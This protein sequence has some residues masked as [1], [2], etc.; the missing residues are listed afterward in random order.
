MALGLYVVKSNLKYVN[1]ME[2]TV[3]SEHTVCRKMQV[4]LVTK[5][6][7]AKMRSP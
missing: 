5:Y 4:S 1:N 3:F 7:I 6:M 2:L